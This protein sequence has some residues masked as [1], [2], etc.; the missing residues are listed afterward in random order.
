MNKAGSTAHRKLDISSPCTE[1]GELVKSWSKFDEQKMRIFVRHIKSSGLPDDVFDPGERRP[2]I[3]KRPKQPE[4]VK[5]T[6]KKNVSPD[7]HVTKNSR[8]SQKQKVTRSTQPV[9]EVAENGAS[10][11][12]RAPKTVVVAAAA[13]DPTSSV[14]A[15]ADVKDPAEVVKSSQLA[16][17][18][19]E[20]IEKPSDSSMPLSQGL[21][22]LHLGH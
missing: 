16:L 19:G 5:S 15:S 7:P 12:P 21:H 14:D 8:S 9:I 20:E 4:E 13:S 1:F 17:G 22:D 6:E 10:S 3:K 11:A 2:V 18:L